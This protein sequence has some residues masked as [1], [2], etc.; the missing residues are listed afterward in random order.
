MCQHEFWNDIL[1]FLANIM[2]EN[3]EVSESD[4]GGPAKFLKH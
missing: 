3:P 2:I 1:V 4:F